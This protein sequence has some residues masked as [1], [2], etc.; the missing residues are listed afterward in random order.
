MGLPKY[1]I[2]ID[3]LTESDGLQYV[4]VVKNW[5]DF[6]PVTQRHKKYHSFVQ[7]F[8]V[9]KLIFSKNAKD[10]LTI[11]R[12]T[13]GGFAASTLKIQA[14][15]A[16]DDTYRDLVDGTIDYDSLD[17]DIVNAVVTARFFPDSE[18]SKFLA[19][20]NTQTN[21]QEL[22]DFD[23]DPITAFS[24]DHGETFTLS[25]TKTEIFGLTE[26]VTS[27]CE[28][29]LAWEVG[30]RLAQKLLGRNDA[31]RSD[32]LGRTDGEVFQTAAD[33]RLAFISFTAGGLVQGNTTTDQ[34]IRMSLDEF[35]D[36]IN[37]IEPVGLGIVNINNVPFLFLED[38]D[39]WFD[40]TSPITLN[41]PDPEG[42]RLVANK[43]R[44]FGKVL[45]G[46]RVFT[47]ASDNGT[48]QTN[49]YF[50]TMHARR[51]YVTGLDFKT[52]ERY[53]IRSNAIASPQ[54]NEFVRNNPSTNNE[55][56]ET[57]RLL[58]YIVVKGD[59]GSPRGFIVDNDQVSTTGVLDPTTQK[60]YLL[61][62]GR[63]VLAHL[64]WINAGLIR[65]FKNRQA[66]EPGF[67]GFSPIKLIDADANFTASTRIGNES[68]EIAEDA[69]LSAGV[70]PILLEDDIII[71]TVLTED[72]NIALQ[73][74]LRKRIS[75]TFNNIT[76]VGYLSQNNFSDLTRLET[77]LHR[78]NP[79]YVAAS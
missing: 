77:R 74:N 58:F 14:L 50:E 18:S 37:A 16:S 10:V 20:V 25:L 46:Y 39:F 23:G 17:E 42:L 3:G 7:T 48:G 8:A 44:I 38:L 4:D 57:A 28:I 64:K 30:V 13:N 27:N 29:M 34:P 69:D 5:K 33:G 47:K 36:N 67:T 52:D 65:E 41:I 55:A 15:N 71:D 60:N 1:K 68:A 61:T 6:L 76:Y 56:D 45:T 59:G 54:L 31:F 22:I 2:E 19:R 62:P 75:V 79:D 21:L 24:G 63:T 12:D 66:T 70:E 78:S 35:F 40:S 9:K 73:D 51:S 49:A 43:D 32:L 11:K 26:I 72:E 53:I